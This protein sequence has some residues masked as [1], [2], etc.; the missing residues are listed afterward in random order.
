M[1]KKKIIVVIAVVVVLYLLYKNSLSSGNKS[2]DGQQSSNAISGISNSLA[3]TVSTIATASHVNKN[4]EDEYYQDL[5]AEYRRLNGGSLP[6]G[7]TSLTAG[8]LENE[9]KALKK[10]NEAINTYYEI[11]DNNIQMSA[12][13]LK[14]KGIDTFEEVQSLINEVRNR[15]KNEELKRIL[16]AF[17]TTC[18]NHGDIWNP[19]GAKRFPWDKS[20]LAEITALNQSDTVAL[21][22]M[23]QLRKEECK[24]PDN[25]SAVSSRYRVRTSL[26]DAI[27]T[28]TL[29]HY[30]PNKDEADKF[31]KEMEKRGC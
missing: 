4:A 18:N 22:K 17:I 12:E 29:W 26:S 21:N 24:Y 3:S 8:Q 5:L 7:A 27:P 31:R 30:R 10:L 14:E 1:D 9:I 20:V 16:D 11:E 28:G 6:R 13:E 19:A 23:F 15:Q 2:E 25:Y